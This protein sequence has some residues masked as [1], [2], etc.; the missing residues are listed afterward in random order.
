MRMPASVGAGSALTSYP[1]FDV[2]LGN[3]TGTGGGGGFNVRA[4]PKPPVLLC[5][6]LR[7]Y[8][9]RWLTH[10]VLLAGAQGGWKLTS[11]PNTVSTIQRCMSGTQ[12]MRGMQGMGVSS[13][14][15][16]GVGGSQKG[17]A[18]GKTWAGAH[19]AA[20]APE[21]EKTLG[22]TTALTVTENIRPVLE[23][24]NL[25]DHL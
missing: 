16:K 6:V 23:R 7:C 4:N 17:G 21:I 24:E 9:S 5:K 15:G 25:V 18:S 12:G 2:E 3:L 19:N 8:E 11:V 14:G 20:A 13:M 1:Q 22:A 10:G